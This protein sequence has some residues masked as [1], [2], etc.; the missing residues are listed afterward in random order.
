MVA[1][2]MVDTTK[3]LLEKMVITAFLR[4]MLWF[5]YDQIVSFQGEDTDFRSPKQRSKNA[6]IAYLSFSFFYG[7]TY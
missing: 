2:R 4:S 5:I 1:M 3:S 7:V 6:N